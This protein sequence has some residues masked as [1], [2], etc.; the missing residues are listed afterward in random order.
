M[1]KW[2]VKIVPMRDPRKIMRVL[3]SLRRLVDANYDD[4][5][6]SEFWNADEIYRLWVNAYLILLDPI[7]G[8]DW[9]AQAR[10]VARI[11]QAR[12]EVELDWCAGQRKQSGQIWMVVKVSAWRGTKHVRWHPRKEDIQAL[13][14]MYPSRP[15]DRERERE[16]R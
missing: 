1:K 2:K 16:R 4:L 5:R 6:P 8:M 7:P 13:V 11:L 3:A 9:T 15:R 10:Q 14:S 12:Q